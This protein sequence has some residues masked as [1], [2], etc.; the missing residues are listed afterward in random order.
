MRAKKRREH[1]IEEASIFMNVH[2]V[3]EHASD[4]ISPEKIKVMHDEDT[5]KCLKWYENHPK[6]QTF[7][8]AVLTMLRESSKKNSEFFS[9]HRFHA[10]L[11][12]ELENDRYYVPSKGNAVIICIA[13]RLSLPHARELLALGGYN[14]TNSRKSDLI[15]RYCIENKIYHLQDITYLLKKLADTDIYS[16]Y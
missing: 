8:D 5:I 12:S 15:I 16:I 14:L 6:V 10:D 3:R 1:L 13:L 2:F 4:R 11:I 7:S 9:K